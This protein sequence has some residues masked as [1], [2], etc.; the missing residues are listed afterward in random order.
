MKYSLDTILMMLD[1]YT[2]YNH[3]EVMFIYYQ[4]NGDV[5]NAQKYK[6]VCDDNRKKLEEQ[7]DKM[8]YEE[9]LKIEEDKL[10]ELA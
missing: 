1:G 10:E 2:Y 4:A 5:E 3:E 9:E 6:T 8:K 7:K